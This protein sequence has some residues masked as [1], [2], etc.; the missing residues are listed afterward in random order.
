MSFNPLLVDKFNND[1]HGQYSTDAYQAF[2]NVIG[3]FGELGII[4]LVSFYLLLIE[5]LKIQNRSNT[6][7]NKNLITVLYLVFTYSI[8]A[9]TLLHIYDDVYYSLSIWLFGAIIYKKILYENFIA[10]NLKFIKLNSE[11]KNYIVNDT[12]NINSNPLL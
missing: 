9:S 10:A 5:I 2:N 12:K 4:G 1:L 8:V 6:K 11:R 7:K 3:F